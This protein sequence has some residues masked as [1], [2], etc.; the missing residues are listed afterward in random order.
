MSGIGQATVSELVSQILLLPWSSIAFLTSND[1]RRPAV[2]SRLHL[3]GLL[4]V[5]I[6]A[7]VSLSP[8][9][10]VSIT[11]WFADSIQRVLRLSNLRSISG[12][13]MELLVYGCGECISLQYSIMF[14]R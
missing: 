4:L 3:T 7:Q 11:G 12:Q 5:A 1:Y 6:N 13:R 2:F 8:L 14:S 10:P 9:L